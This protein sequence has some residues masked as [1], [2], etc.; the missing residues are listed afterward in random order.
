MA[1]WVHIQECVCVGGGRRLNLGVILHELSTLYLK[2][3]SLI[4]LEIAS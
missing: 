2:T 1:M 4:D 3:D